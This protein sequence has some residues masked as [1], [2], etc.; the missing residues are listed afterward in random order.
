MNNKITTK[1]N[2]KDN[3]ILSRFIAEWP[4]YT[5][6]T[7]N[8]AVAD[9]NSDGKINVKDDMILARHIAEWPGY[10]TLPYLN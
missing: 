5:A 4:E 9:L 7:V 8:I 1:I 2:V 6:E 3:M 10:E